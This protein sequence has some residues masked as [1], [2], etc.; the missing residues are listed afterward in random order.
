MKNVCEEVHDNK[1][2][3]C[4]SK[5]LIVLFNEGPI[6]QNFYFLYIHQLKKSHWYKHDWINNRSVQKLQIKIFVSQQRS[7]NYKMYFAFKEKK[8]S[9]I[10][11][12]VNKKKVLIT[13]LHRQILNKFIEKIIPQ[14][15]FVNLLI[16][17]R[18]LKICKFLTSYV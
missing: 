5:I 10:L 12:K 8:R 6:K 3:K 2:N 1:H 17:Q 18:N 11:Y 13:C 9:A 14:K 16:S 15:W 4:M 7:F